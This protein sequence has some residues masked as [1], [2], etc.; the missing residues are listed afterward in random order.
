MRNSTGSLG[1]T[2]RLDD[3]ELKPIPDAES[4]DEKEVF[5]FFGLAS[6]NA[7][8]AEKSL[9]NFTMAYK[10]ID[11][12][13]L[14]QEQ[15]LELYEHLNSQTFGRLL[16]QIKT[17]VQLPDELVEHLNLSLQKRNCLA[18][19]FFYDHAVLMSDESGRKKVIKKLQKLIKL[20]QITDLA[21]ES[22]SL[23]VWKKFGITEEWIE[24]EMRKQYQE[25]NSSINT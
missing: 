6:F 23:K 9:V 14:T 17:K 10:L 20:F 15:W 2:M 19:D 4:S 25:Y 16:N 3:F 13:S 18:H 5:A 11:Q 1:I 24:E 12:S 7:Q 21:V 22:L 8:S